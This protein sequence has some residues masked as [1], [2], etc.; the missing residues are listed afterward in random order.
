M[1]LFDYTTSH[2]IVADKGKQIKAKN[3]VYVP[4]HEE[5]GAIIPEHKPVYSDLLFVPDSVTEETMHELF[6]EEDIP[7][8]ENITEG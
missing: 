5:N 6:V 4:E 8:E 3:D 1:K 2:F 7:K